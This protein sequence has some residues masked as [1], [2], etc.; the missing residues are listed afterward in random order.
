MRHKVLLTL[1]TGPGTMAIPARRAGTTAPSMSLAAG[2]TLSGSKRGLGPSMA[3]KRPLCP[4]NGPGA[5]QGGLEAS[6]PM[7]PIAIDSQRP[8]GPQVSTGVDQESVL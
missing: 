2:T 3:A 8:C 4:Q 6:L 5:C 1:V 7:E